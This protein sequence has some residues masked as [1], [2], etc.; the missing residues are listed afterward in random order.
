MGPQGQMLCL[1]AFAAISDQVRND[2]Y[3]HPHLRYY[4]REVRMVAY[5]Q[6][7]CTVAPQL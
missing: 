3:M 6:V 7:G 2:L 4:M 5:S 1:Q